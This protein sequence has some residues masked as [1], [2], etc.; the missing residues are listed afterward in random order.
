MQTQPHP[1]LPD[2]FSPLVIS[3]PYPAY[4]DLRNTGV[5][6]DERNDTWLVARHRDVIEGLHHPSLYS[7]ERG[8]EAFMSGRV[9]PAGSEGRATAIGLDRLFGSRVLIASD[10]P[11]HTLLRRIVSRPFTKKS[12]AS[13]ESRA[14][15]LADDL[16]GELAVSIASGDADLV[17]DLAVPLPVRL[18]AEVLG[19][20]TDRQADFRRWSDALV[21][22]L[23]AQVDVDAVSGDLAEMFEFFTNV[24]DQRR[25]APGDDLI[26][27]IAQAT[28][29]GEELSIIEVVMFCI[30][31]LVAGNETTTNLLGNLQH[32]LWDHPDQFEL[33]RHRPDLA[34]AAVEEG[35][36]HGGPVQGLFRQTTRACRLGGVHLPAAAN[37]FLLFA[38]ANRDDTVFSEPDAYRIE[39]DTAEHLALGHGIHY[40]LGAQLARL[41]ARAAL[42]ALLAHGLRLQPTGPA[43]ATHNP[44]LRGF[45]SIPVTA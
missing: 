15:A 34:T 39:R 12:I 31:L 2:L 37:V 42:E 30:L 25:R 26:S 9:G 23:A 24:T 27:A 21:G 38:A 1:D 28:P 16:V 3:D 33:L 17:R 36:R 10:P 7:S 35:L 5:A 44:I 32:S 4:A 45:V 6:Y 29:E 22:S 40:C 8:Y 20:P 43:E 14:R 41:E 18:I 11:D 13:W 19:I